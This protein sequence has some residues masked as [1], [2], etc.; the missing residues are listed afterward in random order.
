MSDITRHDYA[1]GRVHPHVMFLGVVGLLTMLCG[2]FGFAYM[3][4]FA[5]TPGDQAALVTGSLT[6]DPHLDDGRKTLGYLFPYHAVEFALGDSVEVRGAF[7]LDANA[8]PVEWDASATAIASDGSAL[9]TVSGK[10]TGAVWYVKLEEAAPE[11]ASER[12]VATKMRIS[13]LTDIWIV[14][15]PKTDEDVY[16]AA[17]GNEEALAEYALPFL[18]VAFAGFSR[19]EE[20]AGTE[21]LPPASTTT[22]ARRIG[23]TIAVRDDDGDGLVEALELLCGTDPDDPDSDADGFS[24]GEEVKNGYDPVGDGPLGNRCAIVE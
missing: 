20:A 8:V 1:P 4:L 19:T 15:D 12:H 13:D 24:D 11:L 2:A 16:A 21:I 14:L 9:L 18:V 3:R 23:E 10:K 17:F 6:I 5:G 7:R 22:F